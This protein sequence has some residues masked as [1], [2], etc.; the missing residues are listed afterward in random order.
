MIENLDLNLAAVSVSGERKLDAQFRGTRKR[1]GVVRKQDVGHIA[2]DQLFRVDERLAFLAFTGALALIVDANEIKLRAFESE[3]FVFL[4]QQRH[5]SLGEERLRGVFDPGVNFVIAIAAPDAQGR[6]QLADFIDALGK[7]IACAGD[8]IAGDDGQVGAQLIGHFD[9]SAHLRAR[10]IAAHVNV[11]QL[12]DGHAVQRGIQTGNGNF[13]A[14]NLVIEALGGVAVHG[15]EE[16]R[17]SGCGGDGAEK[18]TARRITKLLNA[19]GSSRANDE[20]RG[21]SWLCSFRAIAFANSGPQ[22]IEPAHEFYG[23][24][25]KQRAEEPQTDQGGDH[26]SARNHVAVTHAHAVDKSGDDQS[27]HAK[28]YEANCYAQPLATKISGDAPDGAVPEKLGKEKQAKYAAGN[29]KT[30]HKESPVHVRTPLISSS[31]ISRGLWA[32]CCRTRDCFRSKMCGRSC[33]GGREVI[34]VNDI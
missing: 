6:V 10:H 27:H 32:S 19:R 5:A 1:I 29:R 23:E 30:Q 28:P 18:V 12:H 3:L 15:A 24:E 11:A 2:A 33:C 14:A 13:D 16:W 21:R 34:Q 4:A 26:R 22:E 9:G 7:R 8:E 20:L 25:G 31:I 17:G